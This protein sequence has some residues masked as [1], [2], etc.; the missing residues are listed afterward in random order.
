[1]DSSKRI[2]NAA[3]AAGFRTVD[4][5]PITDASVNR[6]LCDAMGAP[7]NSLV[8]PDLVRYVRVLKER[9]RIA[10]RKAR[11]A[12]ETMRGIAIR[13]GSG[14]LSCALCNSVWRPHEGE[15]HD[16]DCKAKP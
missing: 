5:E 15:R 10:E 6:E 1:M 3:A 14:V 7:R 8:H 4:D 2:A 16:D 13:K 12:T 11:T 9:A